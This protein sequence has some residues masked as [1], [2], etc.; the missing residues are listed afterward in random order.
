ML[1]IGGTNGALGWPDSLSDPDPW[2]LG[3]GIF[4]M[5]ELRWTDSYEPKAATYESPDMVKRWYDQGGLK[6]VHWTSD[7]V[8]AL[9]TNC[10]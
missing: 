2:D 3:L 5:T 4:D 9:F 10:E 8:R 6:S 1:S 7:E